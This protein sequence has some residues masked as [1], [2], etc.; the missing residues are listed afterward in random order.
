MTTGTLSPLSD[1]WMDSPEQPEP[2]WVGSCQSQNERMSEFAS[3]SYMVQACELEAIPR[4]SDVI[5]KRILVTFTEVT[6]HVPS[7][8][9]SLKNTQQLHPHFTVLLFKCS[10]S[11]NTCSLYHRWHHTWAA[12]HYSINATPPKLFEMARQNPRHSLDCKA[13]WPNTNGFLVPIIH[14]RNHSML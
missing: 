8:I 5:T 11:P 13:H 2:I 9:Y 1:T 4:H 12:S 7:H 10:D 3:V 14:S 6:A